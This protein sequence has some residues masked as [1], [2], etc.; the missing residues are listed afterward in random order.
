MRNNSSIA[1]II[2][3][4]DLL[5]QTSRTVQLEEEILAE[6]SKVAQLTS[7]LTAEVHAHAAAAARANQLEAALNDERSSSEDRCS[8]IHISLRLIPYPALFSIISLILSFFQSC[9]HKKRIQQSL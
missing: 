3:S 9:Q 8:M 6:R 4:E 1:P 7:Q 5:A 2:L